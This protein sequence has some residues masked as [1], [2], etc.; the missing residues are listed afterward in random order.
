MAKLSPFTILDGKSFIFE[1]QFAT[2]P[3]SDNG[4]SGSLLLNRNK[5]AVG[6]LFA[7][8]NRITYATPINRILKHFNIRFTPN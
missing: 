8:S 1:E 5:K 2:T 6:L 4:D 7:G 3:M